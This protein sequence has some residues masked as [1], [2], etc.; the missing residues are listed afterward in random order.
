MARVVGGQEQRSTGQ[1]GRTR[2]ATH[3]GELAELV[4]AAGLPVFATERCL[5]DLGGFQ[6]R[7]F[8]GNDDFIAFVEPLQKMPG[9]HRWVA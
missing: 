8:I 4:T 6:P 2:Y 1:F 5:H 7:R 3:R 9:Q